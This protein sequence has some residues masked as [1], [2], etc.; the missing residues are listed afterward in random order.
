MDFITRLT[1]SPTNFWI[2]GQRS[3]HECSTWE[4]IEG[5]VIEYF[6]QRKGEPNNVDDNNI[7]EENCIEFR[8]NLP[9]ANGKWNDENCGDKFEFVC[10]SVCIKVDI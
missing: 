10:K 7:R 3:C 1:P 9:E 5:R 4:W 6:S 8:M 2:G